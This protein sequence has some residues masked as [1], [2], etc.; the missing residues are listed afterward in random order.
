MRV[1]VVREAG[2]WGDVLCTLFAVR[3]LR[4]M[5]P[6]AQISYFCLDAFAPLL[7]RIPDIDRLLTLGF[8][9]AQPPRKVRLRR[10]HRH[11]G[12]PFDPALYRLTRSYNKIADL[13]CPADVYERATGGLMER[14]RVEC[15]CDAAGVPCPLVPR[16]P[17]SAEDRAWA[18]DLLDRAVPGTGPRVL[19]QMFSAKV[20]KNWPVAR[21]AHLFGLLTARGFRPFVVL[22]SGAAF[23]GAPVVSGVSHVQAMALASV[24]ACV[25]APDSGFFHAAAAVGTPCVALFGPTDPRP[26]CRHYPLADVHWSPL[27]AAMDGCRPPCLYYPENGFPPRRGCQEEGDCMAA[28]LPENVLLSVER[29]ARERT[30]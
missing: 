10:F 21:W 11:I 8:S 13:W 14:S 16:F 1:L 17:V 2:G 26:Y 22:Q 29:C 9:D 20:T 3:G 23:H 12:Q 5:H 30:V 27:A 4:L 19:C 6:D 25:V 24:S 15:F 7:A 18:E 28:I